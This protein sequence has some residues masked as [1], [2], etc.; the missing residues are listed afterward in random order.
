MQSVGERLRA[1]RLDLGLSLEQVSART[2][3]PVKNLR[4]IEADALSEISSAFFYKSFVRQFADDLGLD[5]GSIAPAVQDA[6][7]TIPAPL[8]PGQAD[9]PLPKLSRLRP[10]RSFKARSFFSVATLAAMV[11]V[12]SIVYSEWRNSREDLQESIMG[13][14][15]SIKAGS[16]KPQS[17]KPQSQ[18]SKSQESKPRPMAT[19]PAVAPGPQTHSDAAS[20]PANTAVSPDAP[21]AS[22]SFELKVSALEATWLSVV[23]D[24]KQIFS[25]ILRP[26][27]TKVLEGHETA[28]LRTG[29]AG[30]LSVE[31]NGKSLGTIG[32]HGQVRTVVFTRDSYEIVPPA[33]HVAF[34]AFTL[35]GE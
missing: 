7:S 34:A 17:Q 28:R 13:L 15:G 27:E 10:K 2:R 32:P 26:S 20:Q 31:F 12:C 1:A 30:G 22:D 19:P 35:Q 33:A 25:G 6:V 29:N 3:I 4:A 16:A 24:G 5:Y 11:V 18:E 14:L 23:A 21:L 9:A 8:I